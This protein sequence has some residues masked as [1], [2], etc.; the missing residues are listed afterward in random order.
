MERN[1]KTSEISG[2]DSGSRCQQRWIK[3]HK[4]S[5]QDGFRGRGGRLFPTIFNGT[6]ISGVPGKGTRPVNTYANFKS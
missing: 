5:V 4:S 2:R 3:F 1:C 6:A